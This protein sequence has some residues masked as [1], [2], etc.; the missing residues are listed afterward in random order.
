[1]I[2]LPKMSPGTFGDEPNQMMFEWQNGIARQK[3]HLC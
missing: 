1:M 2:E 3:V